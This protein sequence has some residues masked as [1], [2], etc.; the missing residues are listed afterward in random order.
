MSPQTFSLACLLLP[1]RH[2]LLLLLLLF[3]CLLL[4]LYKCSSLHVFGS[5]T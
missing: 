4:L 1:L 2:L 5:I 3:F